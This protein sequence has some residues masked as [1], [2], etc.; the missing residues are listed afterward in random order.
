MHKHQNLFSSFDLAPNITLKNRI[1][2]APLIQ[3]TACDRGI[4]DS[5]M[6]D[7][8]AMRANAGLI[9]TEATMISENARSYSNMPG[10]YTKSQIDHWRKIVKEIHLREGKTFIQLW[11]PGRISHRNLLQGKQPLAPSKIR[12]KGKIPWSDLDYD[13]PIEMTQS[14]IGEITHS[15]ENAAQNTLSSEFDGVEIH[16][17]NGY[18]L[19]QFLRDETNKRNDR[20]GGASAN[21]VSFPLKVIDAVI[22]KVG[23]NKVGV[24][25]SLEHSSTLAFN[26]IDLETYITFIQ[27]LNEYP[28]AYIHLSSEN[29]FVTNP[30][31][32]CRPSQFLK[33]HTKHPLIVCGSYDPA[34]AENAL[35]ANTCDLVSFGRLF[36]K[37]ANLVN[38]IRSGSYSNN[39]K[40]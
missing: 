12:A 28:L 4:P 17:A 22:K 35:R 7:F 2:M 24:R 19:E 5:R 23:P 1:V 9:I 26:E 30:I 31:L 6:F 25:I 8:Y 33:L 37:H 40:E 3:R 14:E 39:K 27:R 11:H 29:D 20:Y 38:E 15:Y 18:L 34:L 21:K 32:N 10:I 13:I 16:A 36:L